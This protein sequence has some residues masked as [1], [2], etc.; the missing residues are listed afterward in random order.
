MAGDA[1]RFEFEV[2]VDRAGQ[3]AAED[4]EAYQL[5]SEWQA[6]HLLLAALVRCSLTSFRYH[7]RRLGADAVGSGRASGLVTRRD[8]DGRYAFVEVEA[9]LEL[10]VEPAQAR[11]RLGALLAKAERDCFVA[12][13]LTVAPR[14]AWTVNGVDA[15]ARPRV[16]LNGH[17]GRPRRGCPARPAR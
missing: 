9:R 11:T 1:R 16:R 14:Y 4:D 10:E 7:A 6:E 3:V 15:A 8:S 17:A 2:A 5:P 13:S 12:A